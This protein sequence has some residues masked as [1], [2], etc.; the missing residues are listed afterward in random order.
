[1]EQQEA[2]YFRWLESIRDWCVSRQL[3]W[4]HQIP[5][6]YCAGCDSAAIKRSAGGVVIGQGAKPIV[7][8]EKPAKCP[9]CGGSELVQDPDVLDTWFSSGT[10]PFSTLGWPEQTPELKQFYPTSVLI[11]AYDILF[12]WV[13][14]MMMFG[15]EFMGEVPF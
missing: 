4:G 2:A 9:R 12:F 1:P 3:W 6:W 14:R 13:A 5:A 10:W 11:T 8:M 15:L 7:A